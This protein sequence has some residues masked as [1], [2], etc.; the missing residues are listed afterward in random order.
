M[1]SLT[2]RGI[3]PDMEKIIKNEAKETN[4]SLNKALLSVLEKAAGARAQ[5]KKTKTIYHDLDHL[6]G[7]WTEK[8]ADTFTKSLKRQ[9]KIEAELWEKEK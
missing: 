5:T 6:F 1:K 8:E 3:P 2:I 4:L 9:R 7:R